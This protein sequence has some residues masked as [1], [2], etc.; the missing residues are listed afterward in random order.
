MCFITNI[1]RYSIHD[2][3]GIRTTVFFKGCP[4]RCMWC[5]NPETQSYKNEILCNT[6]NC[7][8]CGKCAGQCKNDAI[9]ISGGK[10]HTDRKKCSSCGECVCYCND[11]LRSVAGKKYTVDELITEVTKDT[12]FY[13]ES[14]GGV[15]LSGGEVMS[16]NID[17]VE[18]IAETLNEKGI[19]VNIDTCGFAPLSSFQR[20]EKYID[21]FLYD[22]KLIDEHKHIEFTGQ[23]NK[24]ILDNLKFLNERNTRIYLRIPVI[25]EVNGNKEAINEIC[26]FIADNHINPSQVSLL[27]YHDFG[28]SKYMR[29]ETEYKGSYFTAPSDDEM[30]S[31]AGIFSNYGIKNVST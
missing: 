21:T 19:S 15:T 13:E 28:K 8:G 2:G 16:N 22:I 27:K 26:R 18:K 20:I 11:N 24:L 5:H 31:F 6:E 7:S 23:S 4:L 9:I 17:F 12:A 1:Q 14:G 3:D 25:K 10:A 30:Q 29:L